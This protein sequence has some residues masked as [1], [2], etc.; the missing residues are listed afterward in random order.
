MN[1]NYTNNNQFGN[2]PNMNPNNQPQMPQNQM[3]PGQMNMNQMNPGQMNM[4]QMNPGQ[5]NMN[6]MNPGQMNMNQ[7]NPGQMNMNQVNTNIPNSEKKKT[8]FIPIV[9]IVII[10]LVIGIALLG[11]NDNSNSGTNGGVLNTNTNKESST[12]S[13]TTI[14]LGETIKI[15][16]ENRG[17]DLRIDS[18]EPKVDMTSPAGITNTY[19]FLT[20]KV[21][22]KKGNT[23][24]IVVTSINLLDANNNK[25]TS[26]PAYDGKGYGANLLGTIEADKTLDVYFK[27]IILSSEMDKVAV[28]AT[29]TEAIY[30]Y[31]YVN[32]E[33]VESKEELEYFINLN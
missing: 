7:M 18:F 2:Y 22:T 23:S 8:N 15:R 26:C 14:S 31:D 4:N 19:A 27:C 5:M 29:Y 1:N 12:P 9:V 11:N 10:A 21:T 33:P 17:Y 20:G 6:Q 28:K 24:K 13:G 32:G 30:S 16:K 3:N 25:I